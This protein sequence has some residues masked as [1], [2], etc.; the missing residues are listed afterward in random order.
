MFKISKN[1]LLA[2]ALILLNSLLFAQGF[3]EQWKLSNGHELLIG[4]EIDK[5]VFKDSTVRRMDI[6]INITNWMT[7]LKN[8]YTSK[9]N[10]PCKV[11][12]NGVTYDSVGIRY[13]GQTSYS[14]IQNDTNKKKSLNLEFD[15]YKTNQ[16]FDEGYNTV[17]LN[18]MYEDQSFMREYL[19]CKYEKKHVPAS[20]VCFVRVYINGNDF[21]LYVMVE[22]V[23][24][25]LYKEWYLSNNGTNIR[26]DKP[27]GSG[28]AGGG[29]GDGTA[30]LNN[31]GNDTNTYKQYY[32]LKSTEKAQPWTDL[33]KVCQQ[34]STTT[35]ANYEA[36][37]TILDID[38]ALWF[39]ATENIYADDDG[40]LFKG[41]MDYYVY[42]DAET[43]RL[44]LQEFDGNSSYYTSVVNT[45]TPWYR[46]TENNFPLAQ[47]LLAIPE[48]RQ[49]Y[50][51]HYKSIVNY[52]LDTTTVFPFIN[53]T[54][55]KIDSIL[56]VDPKKIYT[57]TQF[58]TGVN[59]L[60][61][62]I[63][64]RRNKIY[65]DAEFTAYAP[66]SITNLTHYVNNVQWARPQHNGTAQVNCDV[67]S[68]N[69][70]SS[71][72][73]YYSGDIV[74]RFTKTT[75]YDDGTHNDGAAGDGKYGATI[76]G[77]A[78]GKWV[79]YYVE[80]KANNT[81]KSASYMPEGAEHDVFTYLV[82]PRNAADSL[83][84]INE[85]MASNTST[86]QDNAGEYD[87][88]I[89]LYNKSN[90]SINIGGWN[91]T[92]DELNLSK[93]SIPSGTSMAPNSYL[94]IWADEDGSQ[95]NMHANFK[96]SASGGET[97]YLLNDQLEV[98][99]TVSFGVQT[100]DSGYART[101]NGTGNFVIKRATYNANND[102]SVGTET[103]QL[104]KLQMAVYP[105]PANDQALIRFY[106]NTSDL[107]GNVEMYSSNGS[108]LW[109]KPINSSIQFYTRDLINGIYFIKYNNQTQKLLVQH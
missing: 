47:K 19:Y 24:K 108:L 43:N 2:S 72:N 59:T 83:V 89:E 14:S 36:L 46:S 27:P 32:T 60:K 106:G 5:G 92:D 77:F 90:T 16:T 70:I 17:N 6:T 26:A 30:A 45:W 7:T 48:L 74:G 25:D 64:T 33:V 18:N 1:L 10:V 8:N 40:Y 50:L 81:A 3:P 91:L 65:Q 100:A 97:V 15:F 101:P 94:I 105:N 87:D 102:G 80:A 63:K 84:V 42:I 28:G 49:R 29:W 53:Y 109:S 104:D 99:N 88:W 21:G 41:K 85:L 23:D 12:F 39:L 9:T 66:P 35:A 93:F 44:N 55:T 56:Q 71:V 38:K 75:M 31:L 96:L 11:V 54:K 76:P 68:T 86:V 69:G 78:G 98:V 62:N 13:K 22:Q 103:T 95:G 4:K 58:N 79:R 67:S 37:D 82:Y 51:A 52:G 73:L 20:K 107:K 61:N 57:Y 34:L